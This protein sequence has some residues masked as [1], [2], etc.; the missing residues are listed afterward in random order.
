MSR[1]KQKKIFKICIRICIIFRK[2]TQK[3][4]EIEI[5]KIFY[6]ASVSFEIDKF[7]RKQRELLIKTKNFQVIL[8]KYLNNK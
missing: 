1:E 3:S 4:S 7:K 6:F 5:K 2:S 8:I